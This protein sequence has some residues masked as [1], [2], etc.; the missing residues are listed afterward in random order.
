MVVNGR[1]WV[2]GTVGEVVKGCVVEAAGG[3]RIASAAGIADGRSGLLLAAAPTK[4]LPAGGIW[5]SKEGGDTPADRGSGLPPAA[6]GPTAVPMGA[7][8]GVC[9]S[10]GG[11]I[12]WGTTGGG[13]WKTG[14]ACVTCSI[15]KL[16]HQQ[17]SDPALAAA[18]HAQPRKSVR[19]IIPPAK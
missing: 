10:S 19:A 14:L 1:F 2:V 18:Y 8:G 17:A 15:G 6:A 11:A 3:P 5:E 9:R 4:V 7:A 12:S 16:S 13:S